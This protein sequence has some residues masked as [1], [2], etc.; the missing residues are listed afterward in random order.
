M[1]Q[2]KGLILQMCKFSAV[3]TSCFVIDYVLMIVFTELCNMEYLFSCAFSFTISVVINYILSMQ[4]VFQGKEE[5][6]KIIEIII[7]SSLSVVGLGLNLLLMWG[8]VEFLGFSYIHAK[9]YA[10]LIVTGYNFFSRKLFLDSSKEK[11]VIN[12]AMREIGYTEINS[13]T[14][15]NR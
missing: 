15:I 5:M 7:F 2:L 6:H 8:G 12:S 14:E 9:V 4:F 3:G 11:E 10:S 1:K 13:Y